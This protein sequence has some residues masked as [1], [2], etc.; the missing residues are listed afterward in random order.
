MKKNGIFIL[1]FALFFALIGFILKSFIDEKPKVVIVLK[2]FNSEYWEI[3]KAGAEKGFRDFGADGKVI[4]PKDGTVGAQREMLENVLKEKPDVLI[5]SPTYPDYIIP[6]LE[7]FVEM[8]IPVLLL[9]TDDSWENKT[10]YI[11]TDNF[12]LGRIAG[13]LLASQLQPGDKAAVIGGDIP[14]IGKR[15]EGAKISLEAAGIDIAAEI[16]K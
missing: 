7:G 1:I 13:E 9:D 6:A 2:D 11:G 4:A 15:I 3:I 12:K 14:V 5:V 16:V 10:S 8:N